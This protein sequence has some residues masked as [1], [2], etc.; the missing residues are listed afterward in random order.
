MT[1]CEI[2]FEVTEAV[3]GGYDACALDHPI[4]TQGED[5]ATA[6]SSCS[7]SSWASNYGNLWG[8]NNHSPPTL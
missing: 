5:S 7:I 6:K 3:E 2:I 1:S 8:T 4:F